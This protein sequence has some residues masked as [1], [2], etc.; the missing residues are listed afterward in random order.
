MGKMGLRPA[1]FW[2]MSFLEWRLAAEGFAE[3][4]GHGEPDVP[5]MDEIEAAMKWDAEHGKRG[6]SK[7]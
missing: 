5:T 4:H 3:F 1:D 6:R 7:G 2:G